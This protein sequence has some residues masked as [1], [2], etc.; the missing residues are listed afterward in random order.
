MVLDAA[1]TFYVYKAADPR[2]GWT[3]DLCLVSAESV[4]A[5]ATDEATFYFTLSYEQPDQLT[6]DILVSF[7]DTY[8]QSDAFLS[9]PQPQRMDQVAEGRVASVVGTENITSVS[10]PT[11]L[12]LTG[13]MD[14][15]IDPLSEASL[16]A[17]T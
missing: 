8:E 9:S 17:A 12:S 14:T 4:D 15:F 2:V 7:A 1:G 5:L 13:G 3:L 11:P 16:S 10:P 6:S